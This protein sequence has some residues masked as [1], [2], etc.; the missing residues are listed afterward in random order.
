[1]G[2]FIGQIFVEHR[3]EFI[4]NCQYG[5]QIGKFLDLANTQK[6][7]QAPKPIFVGQASEKSGNQVP[8]FDFFKKYTKDAPK[9]T[10]QNG[11]YT[12]QNELMMF[13]IEAK[14]IW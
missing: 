14:P 10:V 6:R 1:M 3:R 5:K 11:S 4:G 9:K 2:R 12:S 13:R 8:H 7:P